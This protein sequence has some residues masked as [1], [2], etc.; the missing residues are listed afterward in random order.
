[1]EK[2]PHQEY[3]DDLAKKLKEIRDA[4]PESEDPKSEITRAKAEGY[5]EAKKEG[6][7]YK[8]YEKIKIEKHERKLLKEKGSELERAH[9][10]EIQKSI[11]DYLT[12][13]LEKKSKDYDVTW[14][15][16]YS[17]DLA[18][19]NK[20]LIQPFG[21]VIHLT[22]H[23]MENLE[24]PD[25]LIPS[26]SQRLVMGGGRGAPS[27]EDFE[28]GAREFMVR[29]KTKLEYHCKIPIKLPREVN[30]FI[31]SVIVDLR[32]EN[33]NHID[34][35]IIL[36][37]YDDEDEFHVHYTGGAALIS[38]LRFKEELQPIE[39]V[40]EKIEKLRGV[41]FKW[42]SDGTSPREIGVIAEEVAEVFPELVF[43]DREGKPLGVHYDKFVAVLIEAVKDLD[44]RVKELEK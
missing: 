4:G 38:S 5:L 12:P 39:N 32:D 18:I 28:F 8:H 14:D 15:G 44:K 36:K 25:Y 43:L 21:L 31:N 20:N 13:F 40:I 37:K 30:V 41:S 23:N 16:K 10:K 29:L 17:V 11:K 26:P 19:E 7:Y 6:D 34:S 1:M 35:K 2:L 3:R 33:G 27:K 22:L 42:K 9:N 24:V